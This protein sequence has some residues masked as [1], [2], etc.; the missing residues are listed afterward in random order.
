[1]IP[2]LP[3]YFEPVSDKNVKGGE[4]NFYVTKPDTR[5]DGPWSDK[6]I[7]IY[8]PRQYRGLENKLYTWQQE[9]WDKADE[10]EPRRVNLI[11]D[12]TGCN[13]KSTLAAI[14]ELYQRGVDM[15]PVNDAEKLTQSLADVLIASENRNPRTVFIDIPRSMRQ[16]KLYGMYA[17][18]EQ[19]KKG[20]VVDTRY[21]YK[22][23][24]FDSPQVWVFTNTK[25]DM[26]YLSE[27]R[28]KFYAISEEKTLVELLPDV[29]RDS[30]GRP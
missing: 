13:G 27:D 8:I 3:E 30:S 14:M 25:P 28:W 12:V 15:P 18:I 4:T 19:I 1:M 11:L 7:E 6:D 20:K 23:W 10:F 16:D 26:T 21:A 29:L 22:Q 17:A 5:I 9:I 24:W 2:D